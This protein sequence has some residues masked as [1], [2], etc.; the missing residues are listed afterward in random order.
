MMVKLGASET[1]PH[2]PTQMISLS[3]YIFP[4]ETLRVFLQS[5]GFS[6]P[7]AP[8]L[9]Q[10]YSSL[11]RRFLSAQQGFP[12]VS[13]QISILFILPLRSLRK[14]EPFYEKVL[15]GQ[16]DGLHVAEGSLIA[17]N[18]SSDF[19]GLRKLHQAR[20]GMRKTGSC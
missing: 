4:F 18:T 13:W 1:L 20:R 12:P 17:Q 19:R 10:M 5:N 11:V 2:K 6:S 14:K 9:G 3:I 16:T 7:L 15:L 8:C